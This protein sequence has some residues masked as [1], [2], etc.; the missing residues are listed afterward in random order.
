MVFVIHWHES[1][2]DLHVFP[3]PI[4]PPTSLSTRFLWVFPVHPL[5]AFRWQTAFFHWSGGEETWSHCSRCLICHT[6]VIV[7]GCRRSARE[8]WAFKNNGYMQVLRFYSGQATWFG[9]DSVGEGNCNKWMKRNEEWAR[10]VLWEGVPD[11]NQA[12]LDPALIKSCVT[13]LVN[14]LES[15]FSYLW[16]EDYWILLCRLKAAWFPDTISAYIMIL[17]STFKYMWVPCLF[18]TRNWKSN[19]SWRFKIQCNVET[20]GWLQKVYN[21]G[22]CLKVLI[23]STSL[24]V[25]WLR[26]HFPMQ[27]VRRVWSPVREQRS[28]VPRGQKNRT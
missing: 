21:A 27:G 26:L 5:F 8:H 10:E 4:P 15:Q 9:F 16:N 12:F 24:V 17:P 7:L 14:F 6:T 3:I 18:C 25:Q 22:L 19:L 13:R 11:W 28:H 2:M 20:E 1:A 23:T